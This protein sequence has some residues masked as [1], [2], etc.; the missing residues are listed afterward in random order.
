MQ[1][2]VTCTACGWAGYVECGEE[3]CPCCEA[4]GYFRWTDPNYPEKDEAD[5]ADEGG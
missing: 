3:I 2:D 1:D 5:E 4:E